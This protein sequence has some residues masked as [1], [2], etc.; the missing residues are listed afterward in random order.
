MATN[1]TPIDPDDLIGKGVTGLPDAP[2]LSTLNMQKKFDELSIDVI[3]PHINQM[4]EEIDA[5][6]DGAIETAHDEM[7]AEKD[8]AEAAELAL[9]TAID[10]ETARAQAAESTQSDA[11]IA[12]TARAQ[13]AEGAISNSV[14]A[15]RTRAQAAESA[16]TTRAQT[17]E[18]D[19]STAIR[20]ETT[21]AQTEET[22]LNRDIVTGVS[23]VSASAIAAKEAE[24]R[25]I[26]AAIDAERIAGG[27]YESL[28][29]QIEIT[30]ATSDL[31][32]LTEVG[33]YYKK[34]VTF[35]CT[36]CPLSSQNALFRMSVSQV[37]DELFAQTIYDTN[38][39]NRLMSR[40]YIYLD[41]TQE[42]AWGQ[43]IIQAYRN[44]Y[45]NQFSTVDFSNMA[46]GQILMST[47]TL[48]HFE[49]S[50]LSSCAYDSSNTLANI[51]GDVETL[52]AA[53]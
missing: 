7:L 13:A 21:R 14:T 43:W 37:S 31:N 40:Y 48:G 34:D 2:E 20:A 16:E 24:R 51:I 8:R 47:D 28:I 50:Y 53:L 5:A 9:H 3:I 29:G 46:A 25:A 44:G 4:C 52:L 18:S 27:K 26:Q 30:S 1:I 6:V 23:A 33:N 49:N 39:N 35:A 17:A 41:D 32:T 11:I 10:N 38:S 36:N 12:E 45:L 15:E 42:W 22:K 19:L